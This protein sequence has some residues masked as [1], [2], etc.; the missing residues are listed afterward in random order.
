MKAITFLERN[1]AL[2]GDLRYERFGAPAI[3]SALA[4]T[5]LAEVL[6]ELGRFDEALAHAEAGVCIAEAVDHP[7]TLSGGLF[8]L[9]LVLLRRGEL[10]RATRVLEQCLDLCRTWQFAR[11]P[12][13]TTILGATYVLGGRGDEAL[14]LVTGAVEDHLGRPRWAARILPFA[15]MIYLSTGRIDEAASHAREA[16]AFTRRAEARASEAHAL[17]LVGDVASTAGEDNNAAERSYREALTLAHDL[18][19]RPLV[20]HCHFGLGK[21]Y[22]RTG[23]REQAHQHLTTAT[24]MY[25]EMGMRFWL[26][27]TEKELGEL[28]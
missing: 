5:L 1:V 21:L 4:E 16:L 17:C 8:S 24:R 11:V 23:R 26:E 2:E 18:G 25:R 15:G 13:A 12:S 10:P 22:Q 7:F 9:G 14:S 6:S 3:Q 19:M 28:R 27:Q 20:A